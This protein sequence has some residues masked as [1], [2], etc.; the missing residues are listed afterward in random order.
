MALPAPPEYPSI[1]DPVNFEAEAD[2]WLAWVNE[3]SEAWDAEVDAQNALFAASTANLNALIAAAGFSGTSTSSNSIGTGS[4]TF[5][6]QTSKAWV[7]GSRLRASDTAAPTANY[8]AGIVTAYDPVAVTD[9]LTVSFDF[10]TG[11]GTKTAWTLSLTGEPGATLA[12][13]TASDI[14]AGTDDDK[15]KTPKG[16]MDAVAFVQASAGGSYTLDLATGFNFEITLTSDMTFAVPSNLKDGKA[17]VIT[18]LQVGSGG[19][20]NRTVTFNGSIRKAGAAPT[21]P[22]GIGAQGRIGYI[23]RGGVFEITAME[24]VA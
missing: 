8:M 1:A 12:K 3:V 2:A 24:T 15:F 9:N 5:T 23:V 11:S 22:T 4:K 19:T 17:G 6:T 16:D 21:M 10:S 13:A 18:F 20:Y 14:R 7:V